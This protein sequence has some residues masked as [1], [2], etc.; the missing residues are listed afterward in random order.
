MKDL[1]QQLVN[2]DQVQLIWLIVAITGWVVAVIWIINNVF[3]RK[4]IKSLRN[5]VEVI[6]S[7][8]RKFKNLSEVLQKEN[9]HILKVNQGMC[10]RKEKI[11]KEIVD[12]LALRRNAAYMAGGLMSKGDD[13]K[14]ITEYFNE[15]Y[16][17][18]TG[19]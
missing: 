6:A 16:S 1:I 3:L 12:D 13:P 17:C 4:K 8:V 11:S 5:D 18:L 9:I 10:L 19:K 14:R 15:I 2:M 7:G